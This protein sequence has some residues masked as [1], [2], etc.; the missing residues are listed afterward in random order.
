MQNDTVFEVKITKVR[1]CERKISIKIFYL[2][3]QRAKNRN[4]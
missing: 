2:H 4:S 3:Y 1:R